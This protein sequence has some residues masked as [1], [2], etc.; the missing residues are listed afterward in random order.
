MVPVLLT[1][2]TLQWAPMQPEVSFKR[3]AQVKLKLWVTLKSLIIL[4]VSEILL[5]PVKWAKVHSSFTQIFTDTQLL[6]CKLPVVL[7]E[8]FL[9]YSS[10]NANA[11]NLL[12][13]NI[14]MKSPKNG[15]LA[16]SPL[17]MIESILPGTERGFGLLNIH[18]FLHL[19]S[20]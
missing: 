13:C 20:W 14:Q 18:L 12:E 3:E 2:E 1:N 9:F 6:L 10:H 4:G 19:T 15:T 17:Q 7:K 5:P 8:I 11:Y 16:I